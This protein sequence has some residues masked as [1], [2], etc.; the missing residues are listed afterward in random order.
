MPV[1]LSHVFRMPIA[2]YG[3]DL[4]AALEWA[5][6]WVHLRHA[7]RREA[8]LASVW[9][10]DATLLTSAGVAPIAPVIA[11]YNASQAWA[12]PFIITARRE[13]GRAATR[14]QLDEH[15]IAG[16]RRLYM[17]PEDKERRLTEHVARQKQASR[18]RIR[19]KH[20]HVVCLNVGDQWSDHFGE[21]PVDEFT[22]HLAPG[23]IYVFVTA[24]GVCHVKLQET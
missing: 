3:G 23:S 17:H 7:A 2:D 9:D 20:G 4:G 19:D 21:I 16:Y 5:R 22:R 14:A 15:S 1:R 11:H 24:D 18:E 12:T 8:P 6:R 13:Q 10:I